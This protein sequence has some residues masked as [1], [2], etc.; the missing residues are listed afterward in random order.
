MREQDEMGRFAVD[1][2][3]A[4]FRDVAREPA[5]ARLPDAVPHRTLSAIVDTGAARLVLPESVVSALNLEHDGEATVRYADQRCETR[6]VV[7]GVW[8]QLMG[9]DGVFK[10][11]VEPNRTDALLGAYV[12]EELDLVVDCPTQTLHPREPDRILAE[13]E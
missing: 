2:V 10:A 11:I 13:I 4:N 12:L 5:G 6:P 3:L 8:L 9:R 1:I 7:S